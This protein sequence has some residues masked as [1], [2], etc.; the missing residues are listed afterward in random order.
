[1]AP[2]LERLKGLWFRGR[3]SF[4]AL[5]T[6]TRAV[7][8]LAGAVACGYVFWFTADVLASVPNRDEIRALR[9][10]AQA[11]VLVDADDRPVF[12]LAK[13]YRLEV[14]LTEVSPHFIHAVVAIEDRRFFDHDGFDPVRIFGSALAVLRAG[15]AVQG[16]STI[17]QQLARQSLGRE[18]TLRRKLKELLTAVELERHYSKEEILEIYLNKVYFGDG[19]YGAEAAARGYFGKAAS[20]VTVAEAAMLAGIIRAPSAANPRTNMERATERRNVVLKLMRDNGF[21]EKA[22]HETAVAEAVALHDDLRSDDPTG[23]HFKEILRRQLI[24]KFGKDAIYQERMRV[25]TTIDADMQKAAE[26]AV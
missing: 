11:N 4:R 13:E 25:Y 3:S 14:P 1:M 12:S 20:D 23:L 16:G 24:E 21:I 8:V 22:E 5:P 2:V 17:T 10:M 18:K 26:A 19:L 9:L 6:R 15:K 7:L